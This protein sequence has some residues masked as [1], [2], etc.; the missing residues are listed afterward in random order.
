MNYQTGKAFRNALETRI[1]TQSAQGPVSLVRLR[2]LVAFD[3]F[4][5]RLLAVQPDRWLLKGGLALQLRLGHRAR[6]T[7]DIDVLLRL[8]R[9]EIGPFLLHAAELDLGDFF[10]F[11]VQQDPE[12]LPGPDAGGWRFFVTARVDSRVFETFHV[13]IGLADPVLEPAEI[14][15]TPPLLAFAGIPPLT[16]PCYPLSQHLAEKIHAYVKQRASGANTRVKDLVDILLIAT[17]SPVAAPALHAAILATFAAQGSGAPPTSL[18]D[19]PAAWPAQY[20]KLA[21][22]SGL[23]ATTLLLAIMQARAFLDPVLNGTAHGNWAPEK[24]AWL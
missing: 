1:L 14:L 17:Y 7:K 22:E 12:P 11:T 3:R 9:P 6:T 16:L 2:K 5:A 13:D 23:A 8:A 10:S 15:T 18:P 21:Q 19:P 24:Q 20:R 4:L